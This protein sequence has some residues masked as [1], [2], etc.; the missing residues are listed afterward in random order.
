[1]TVGSLGKIVFYVS[2]NKVQTF[3]GLKL[4]HS[5]SFGSHKRHC[6]NEFVEFTGN[7]AGTATIEIALSQILGSDVEAELKRLET[8]KKTGE[9]LRFVIGK[10]QLGDY[11]W[12]ITDYTVTPTLYGKK[13]EIITAKVSVSLKEYL[14]AMKY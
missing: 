10:K 7:N 14:K 13:S 2:A 9:T 6:S 8:Y 3:S 5:A 4:K 12:V 11:R 1:M